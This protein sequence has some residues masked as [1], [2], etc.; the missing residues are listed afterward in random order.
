MIID[1]A[2]LKLAQLMWTR[3]RKTSRTARKDPFANGSRDEWAY[4]ALTNV[5]KRKQ[6]FTRAG[7]LTC[8]A[9]QLGEEPILYFRD[10]DAPT[11]LDFLD[12]VQ[13]LIPAPVLSNVNA[14][15]VVE[16]LANDKQKTVTILAQALES[17][18]EWMKSC[19]QELLAGELNPDFVQAVQLLAVEDTIFKEHDIDLEDFK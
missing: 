13:I 9:S 5:Q 2:W 18:L 17:S 7:E 11:I 16:S 15:K 12:H 8:Q 14:S 4:E 19:E 6:I 10:D 1:D 3:D